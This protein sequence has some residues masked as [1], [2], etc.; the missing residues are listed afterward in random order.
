MVGELF[1]GLGA[2]KTMLDLA[3]GLK[4]LNDATAR[5]AVAI[6]LQEKILAAQGQQAVLIEKVGQLEKHVADLE[7]WDTDK[8]RYELKEFAS[9]QFAYAL[10]PEAAAG[11]PAHM[12]CANC[13][14]H[15]EKSILQTETRFPGRHDVTFCPNCGND[16]FS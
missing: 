12:L 13:Y 16:M 9:G 7:A 14:A 8:H 11:D 6:E 1:D 15:N 2:F 4:D 5:S 3:K 10:K